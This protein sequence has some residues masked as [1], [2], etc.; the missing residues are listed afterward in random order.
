L[1]QRAALSAPAGRTKVRF[2]FSTPLALD[3]SAFDARLLGANLVNAAATRLWLLETAYGVGLPR[4]SIP[5]AADPHE[6]SSASMQL[7]RWSFERRSTRHGRV[8]RLAGNMG[9][10]IIEGPW[11]RYTHLLT[12]LER[13]GIGRHIT[14]GF[15]RVSAE[16]LPAE[17]LPRSANGQLKISMPDTGSKA[18][19]TR[20]PRWIRLRGAPPVRST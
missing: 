19:A 18:R 13:Y 17:P 12:A 10:A 7:R 3:P 16:H 20:I 5:R 9:E 11:E 1:G 14:F 4:R 6:F 15:G 2:A 8:V